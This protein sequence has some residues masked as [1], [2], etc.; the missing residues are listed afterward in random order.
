MKEE[1]KELIDQL[2]KW[3]NID[4]SIL[5]QNTIIDWMTFGDSNSKFF[6]TTVKV[7]TTRNIID[8]LHN[9]QGNVLTDLK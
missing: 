4:E 8:V 7:R 6:F 2:R 3:S 9:S 5:K 1:E